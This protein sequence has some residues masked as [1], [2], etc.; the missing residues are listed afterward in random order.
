MKTISVVHK[1]TGEPRKIPVIPWANWPKEKQDQYTTKGIPNK[2]P[3]VAPSEK[4]NPIQ[5]GA[6]PAT[7]Q[8]AGK[9][10]K[11]AETPKAAN[12]AA[13]K[14]ADSFTLEYVNRAV[15][16]A[17][18]D[19]RKEI[20]SGLEELAYKAGFTEDEFLDADIPTIVGKIQEVGL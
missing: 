3:I 7:N 6:E 4:K 9:A 5:N 15:E 10:K 12:T 19:T 16:R 14:S 8:G 17:I 20:K 1:A 2:K 11:V 13:N 18:G